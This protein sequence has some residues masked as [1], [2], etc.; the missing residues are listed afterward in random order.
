[1]NATDLHTDHSALYDRLTI[2]DG[3]CSALLQLSAVVLSIGIIPATM[4]NVLVAYRLLCLVATGSF[5]VVSILSLTVIWVDWIPSEATVKWRT[6]AYRLAVVLTGLGL[7]STAA[8][9]VT[10]LFR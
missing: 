9:V 3:K 6:G 1:M 5:L 8:L 2:L 4:S 10:L 7:L